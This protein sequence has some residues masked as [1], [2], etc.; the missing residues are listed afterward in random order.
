VSSLW[1]PAMLLPLTFLSS[2][3]CSLWVVGTRGEGGGAPTPQPSRKVTSRKNH[4][5]LPALSSLHILTY[6]RT[7]NLWKPHSCPVFS[8]GL[9]KPL[10]TCCV[11]ILRVRQH[12]KGLLTKVMFN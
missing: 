6:V 12:S 11:H 4:W 2:H 10:G 1:S 3:T 9:P 5:A 7:L 8:I